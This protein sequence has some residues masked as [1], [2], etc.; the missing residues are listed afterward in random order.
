MQ[1]GK[2]NSLNRHT[3]SI[4]EKKTG[5]GTAIIEEKA[6]EGTENHGKRRRSFE[7]RV[8]QETENMD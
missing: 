4:I 3:T 1:P 7:N 5:E 6:S 8:K 2:K